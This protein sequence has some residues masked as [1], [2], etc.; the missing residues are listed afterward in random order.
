MIYR[1]R[2]NLSADQAFALYPDIDT[3]FSTEV[4][5]VK[6]LLPYHIYQQP[7]HDLDCIRKIKGKGKVT[8]TDL[9]REEIKGVHQVVVFFQV[10]INT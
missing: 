8:G 1:V 7:Q 3:P 6:R 9:L 10:T 2:I 5:V 4:D